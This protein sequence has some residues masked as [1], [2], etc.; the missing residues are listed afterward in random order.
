MT[1]PSTALSSSFPTS[2]LTSTNTPPQE[3]GK[4]PFRFVVERDAFYPIHS[5][6]AS[7]LSIKEIRNVK[8][9]CKEGTELYEGLKKTS[10]GI[11][12][13]LR[14][15]F[16]DVKEFRCLQSKTETLIA[17]E[18]VADFFRRVDAD[19]GHY[20]NLFTQTGTTADVILDLLKK[21]GYV[22]GESTTMNDKNGLQQVSVR[23]ILDRILL[24]ANRSLS[25]PRQRPGMTSN[26]RLVFGSRQTRP[27]MPSYSVARS[28]HGSVSSPG[29]RPTV[30]SRVA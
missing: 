30:S 19:G 9:V 7:H 17:G 23:F 14:P 4:N 29:T 21:E 27:S 6:I 15:Y 2:S 18:L 10:W 20:L 24:T 16:T 11:E 1:L 8:M 13:L 22:L 5:I 28:R 26:S 3:P 25:F 12:S